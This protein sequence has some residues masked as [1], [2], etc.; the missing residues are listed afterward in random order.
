MYNCMLI[1]NRIFDDL[2]IIFSTNYAVNSAIKKKKKKKN[3]FS[4]TIMTV[5]H[6][7]QGISFPFIILCKYM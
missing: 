3:V 6:L 4:T 7:Y 5:K 2:C 1:L